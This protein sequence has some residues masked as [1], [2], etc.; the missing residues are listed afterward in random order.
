MAAAYP[1]QRLVYALELDAELGQDRRRIPA[2]LLHDCHQQMFTGN[3]IVVEALGLLLGP[4]QGGGR[5]RGDEYL[6]GLLLNLRPLLQQLVE[7]VSHLGHG[8]P[9]LSQDLGG[10]ALFPLQQ[11]EEHVLD[12]P[13]GVAVPPHDL[14][15]PAYDLLGLLR[16]VVGFEN[17]VAHLSFRVFCISVGTFLLMHSDANRSNN[18]HANHISLYVNTQVI[19]SLAVSISVSADSDMNRPDRGNIRQNCLPKLLPWR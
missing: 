8:D 11:R 19:L 14:L 7:A 1:L 13:L 10:D 9:Q 2:L 3:E 15:R 12:V 6:V 16:K 18:I 17:H 5:P 4:L